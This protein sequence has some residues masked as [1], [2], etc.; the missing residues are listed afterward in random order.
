MKYIYQVHKGP[1][2]ARNVG[3]RE[4]K[5]DLI[6]MIGDD[7]IATPKLLEEHLRVHSQKREE[8]ISVLGHIAWS[9]EIRITPFMEYI[10]GPGG[11]Q[12]SYDHI[13]NARDV[14][15]RFFYS[16]NISVRRKFLVENGLFDEDFPYAAHE[17]IELGYRLSKK[18][19]RI[20]YCPAA[21]AYHLHY[22]TFDEFCSRQYKVGQSALLFARKHPELA[23]SLGVL[24]AIKVWEQNQ[25]LLPLYQ[26]A[27]SELEKLD[28][29]I[30]AHINQDKKPVSE[31][32]RGL[33]YSLY[34]R[35]LSIHKAQG[36]FDA[37]TAN[38]YAT[39]VVVTRGQMPKCSI[40]IPVF[41]RVE[42]TKHCISQLL[43]NTQ[44]NDYEIIVV[45]NGSTDGTQRYL[46]SLG[47][48]I[49]VHRN[50]DN[51][52][53]AKACNQGAKLASGQYLIFLN[54]DTIPQ[55][56]WLTEMIDLAKSDKEVGIVGSKL[57]Y[58]NGRIQHAGIVFMENGLPVH[59]YRGA[60]ADA[61]YVNQC[62]E[63]RAVTGA[64]LLIC[65]DL[66][67]QV[68]GFDEAFLNGCEDVDLCLRVGELGKKVI[69]CPASE[70]I[71]FESVTPNRLE[72]Y[73]ENRKLFL[74]R[75]KDKIGRD[76]LAYFAADG[77]EVV[78][79]TPWNWVLRKDGQLYEYEQGF[80]KDDGRSLGGQNG[81]RTHFP[82]RGCPN[83]D[84][85]TRADRL[86]EEGKL[87]EAIAAYQQAITQSPHTVTAYYKLALLHH[88]RGEIEEAIANFRHVTEL[89]PSNV[90][91]YHNLGVLY[92]KQGRL[93]QAEA[94]LRQAVRL[95]D[96]YVEAIY[97]LGR[98][99]LAIGKLDSAAAW[100]RRCLTLAPDHVKARET[101]RTC[102]ERRFNTGPPVTP[103]TDHVLN[104]LVTG[105]TGFIGRALVSQLLAAGHRVW[106]LTRKKP[107]AL[108]ALTH[109]GVEILCGNIT[110]PKTLHDLVG[111][112]REL[113]AVFH[114]AAS[115]DY[116]GKTEQLQQ[117]NVV[118]TENLLTA[119]SHNGHAGLL[120]VYT[121][122]IEAAGLV[123]L[124]QVP[125]DET[126]SRP[127]ASPY[128]DSKLRAEAVVSEWA[129]AH[130]VD[131]RILRLGNVYGPG[132]P[133]FVVPIARSILSDD[134][135][136]AAL[137][138]FGH[139]Y[140]HL[141]YIDDIVAGLMAQLTGGASGIY[142]LV[143]P[144]FVTAMDL[145]SLVSYGL[146]QA[147]RI[148]RGGTSTLDRL[149]ERREQLKQQGR[150]D[151]LSYIT[152]GDG[153]AIHRAYA[154]GKARDSFGFVPQV[155]LMD[156]LQHALTWA[157]ENRKLGE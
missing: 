49:K 85:L 154:W 104:V 36:I 11:Q 60:A 19:L 25:M 34:G 79:D 46:S 4:A 32:I 132:T 116:F 1:G 152:A 39:E 2:A 84:L 129:T 93:S 10:T 67:Q 62:R 89:D 117:V 151:L 105:G 68:G 86:A 31:Y 47:E 43:K 73:Q 58:P 28:L 65:R 95:D 82:G 74:T 135:M 51:L 35:T 134:S 38:N 61:P 141:T 80:L 109:Q 63:F 150:A 115:L 59:I 136:L 66:Y 114:L 157:I 92:F 106:V 100:L 33:L 37:Q 90:S 113:N 110:C 64:C 56:K 142:N 54:N 6:L 69:Y 153:E 52:G 121:S 124:D 78:R 21:I 22:V 143:G 126:I 24:S 41:N 131:C 83:E 13:K 81:S 48:K 94:S 102:Q 42:F 123:S 156:G 103:R 14:S 76:D 96:Q 119:L 26:S 139:I 149:R 12:F 20:V 125:A 122:S 9:P 91:S 111:Q 133:A 72:H 18:G 98:V 17:D 144:E 16:S 44:Y 53:F 29:D 40:I 137:P 101:L 7:I 128:G 3:I 15:Y 30:L 50:D 23:D 45:D 118:G 71:H 70:V 146:G 97:T 99:L 27:I 57:L 155:R 55:G 5:G 147:L 140:L 112:L 75:W 130:D 108:R 77:F 88:K 107:E 127:P 87:D 138:A 145:F 8:N 148:P 120:F